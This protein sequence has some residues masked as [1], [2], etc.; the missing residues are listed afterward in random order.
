MS[1]ITTKHII[2]LVNL[3]M[4]DYLRQ[5]CKYLAPIAKWVMENGGQPPDVIPFSVE[6]EEKLESLSED[7]EKLEEFLKDI[8]VK[9]RLNKIIT[10][11]KYISEDRLSLIDYISALTWRRRIHQARSA[12]LL[13]W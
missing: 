11:G 12:V 10:E 6:F 1:L 2:Y 5:K 7:E 4:K 9:S 3:T 13:Y 8:K